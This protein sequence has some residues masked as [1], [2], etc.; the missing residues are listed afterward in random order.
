MEDKNLAPH[1]PIVREGSPTPSNA[2]AEPAA[3][4]TPG[5]WVC[6]ADLPSTEPDWHIV[7]TSNRLRVLAN[8][9]IEPGNKTDEANARLIAAAPD[10]LAIALRFRDYTKGPDGYRY[11]LGSVQELDAAIAKATGADQ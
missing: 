4:H 2:T 10:L 7:T 9:H 1:E 8:V 11:P 5:P 3:A 6:Y